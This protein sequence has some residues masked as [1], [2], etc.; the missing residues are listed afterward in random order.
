[1]KHKNSHYLSRITRL[2]TMLFILTH[3]PKT[4]NIVKTGRYSYEKIMVAY[5]VLL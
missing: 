3:E 2:R 5:K 4:D 1:M